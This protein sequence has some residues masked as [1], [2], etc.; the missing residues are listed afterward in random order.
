VA[1]EILTQ[2]EGRLSPREAAEWT[3]LDE[4][5]M[6][7]DEALAGR[8]FKVVENC[9]VEWSDRMKRLHRRWRGI[10]DMLAGN[11]MDKGGPADVHVPEIYKAI[12]TLVPRIE[13]AILERDPWFRIVPRRFDRRAKADTLAAYIDWQ[14]DQSNVA[15]LIQPAIR[16]MLVTQSAAFFTQWDYRVERRQV[17]SIEREFDRHGRMR[18]KRTRREDEVVTQYGPVT[19]LIDPFDFIIDTKAT[20]PQNAIYVGH[21]FWMTPD[22]IRRVGHQLGWTNLDQLEGYGQGEPAFGI[23]Q[24]WYRWTRDPTSLYGENQYRQHGQDGRPDPI[25]VVVLHTLFRKDG[26]S[27]YEDHRFVVS[28]GRKVHEVRKNPYQ[29]ALRPYATA[30]STKSGHEFYG[31]GTFDNAVRLN[32][33]LDRY[34][35]TF[36]QMAERTAGPLVFAEEDSDLPDNLYRT[37]PF[38]VFKGVGPVRFSQIP[39]GALRA[40]PLVLGTLQ[41][42]IEEVVG[43]PR[44]MMGQDVT[45]GTATESTIAWREGNRRTRGLIRSFGNGLKQLLEVY[46]RLDQQYSFEDVEFP[47]L[48]KRALD[49]R[50]THGNVAPEDLLDDVQFDLIGLHGL[51]NVGLKATGLQA[52]GNTMAPF[53]MANAQYVNQPALL[54]D[55]TREFVGPEEADRYIRVPTSPDR[56]KSQEEENE[57]LIAG[58]RIEVDPED[59]D[60]SHMMKMRGLYERAIDPDSEMEDNVRVATVEHYLNHHYQRQRKQEQKKAMDRMR[61][62]PVAAAA[63]AA[64][65]PAAGQK[66]AAPQPGGMSNALMDLASQPSG[67]LPQ[68]NPG[69]SDTRKSPRAGGSRRTVAQT[70]NQL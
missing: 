22:E 12:E 62:A 20:N 46:Y 32:Q 37:K 18:R 39:D 63:E 58:E 45:G 36:L 23:N 4:P 14:F 30:R 25:E 21:R 56:L 44:I 17:W 1:T 34:H 43:T 7:G 38:S 9:Y 19:R 70:E 47:I 5:N 51:S 57:G 8:A 53:L 59:D 40:A 33:H 27:E 24:D 68:E 66:R 49:L 64:G 35:A 41:R 16:N 42:N 50:R 10:Y 29:G 61:P 2:D 54:H 26:S 11:S 52:L 6:A 15:D 31:T 28:G 67:Q 55:F 69:P 13:E 3:R 65:E 60:E 48:G